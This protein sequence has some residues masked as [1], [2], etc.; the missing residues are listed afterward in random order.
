L[1]IFT[2]MLI[3]ATLIRDREEEEEVSNLRIYTHIG[4]HVGL[5]IWKKGKTNLFLLLIKHCTTDTR[6]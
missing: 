5:L 4:L 1:R 6:G 2:D 3:K